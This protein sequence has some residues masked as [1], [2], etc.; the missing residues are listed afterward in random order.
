METLND[1]VLFYKYFYTKD[2]TN[3]ENLLN[4]NKNI[5]ECY[6]KYKLLNYILINDLAN[7][8]ELFNKLNIDYDIDYVIKYKLIYKCNNIL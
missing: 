3:L 1:K 8:L 7:Y 6:D 5:I 2:I 4:T